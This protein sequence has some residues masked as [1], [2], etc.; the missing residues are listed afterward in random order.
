[1][2]MRRID[3]S[4]Q[5]KAVRLNGGWKFSPSI[6]LRDAS[7]APRN[8]AIDSHAPTV[9]YNGMIAPLWPYAIRG[10]TWYQ[11][12]SNVSRAREYRSL[13]PA[14]IADWREIWNQGDFP[15]LFVQIAPYKNMTP[16]LREAQLLTLNKSPNTAMAVTIDCGD[17]E[18]IHPADKRPVG[19][20][21]ALAARALVYEEIVQYSGPV[22]NSMSV[23]EGEV[24]LRFSHVGEALVARDGELVGFTIAGSDGVF[25]PAVARI[26]EY[27]VVVSSEAVPEPAAV[28]YAWSNVPEASLFNKAG[29]PA[30]PF[31]TD[32]E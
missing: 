17:A 29:L 14:M 7:P 1:M 26:E 18:D 31:R 19:Q 28:R 24:V 15:F 10:V 32:V 2:L 21:L 6:A 27:T 8:V 9:L 25:H 11:G 5:E 16:E 12:E 13:F 22:Y 30:S 20:R 4:P 3:A 23:V